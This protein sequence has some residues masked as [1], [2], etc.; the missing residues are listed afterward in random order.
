MHALAAHPATK[1]NIEKWERHAVCG[2]SNNNS[3][4]QYIVRNYFCKKKNKNTKKNTRQNMTCDAHTL[5]IQKMRPI[6]FCSEVIFPF[7][8]ATFCSHTNAYRNTKFC[9][10]ISTTMSKENRGDSSMNKTKTSKKKRFFGLGESWQKLW[11]AFIPRS[12]Q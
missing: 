9:A 8:G 5:H 10:I 11:V 6:F 2:N 12:K 7:L 1:T 4:T 3:S